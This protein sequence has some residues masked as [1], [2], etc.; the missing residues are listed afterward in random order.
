MWLQLGKRC[1]GAPV[2]LDVRPATVTCVLRISGPTLAATL[3]RV[4]ITPYRVENGSAHFTV[5]DADMAD[6]PA[7]MRDA[8]VFLIANRTA[9]EALMAAPSTSGELDFAT[10][11]EPG[12]F[13]SHT[14]N[15]K[16][17]R[18]AGELCLDLTVSGYPTEGFREQA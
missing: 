6:L 14:L 11:Y 3:A 9:I 1:T 10:E 4:P 13:T 2:T 7:Q 5:S 17:V 12:A 18:L 8:E 15:A 16:L